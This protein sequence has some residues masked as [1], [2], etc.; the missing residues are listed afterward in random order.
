MNR[1]AAIAK[2]KKC[3]ALGRSAEAHE[4]AA[5]IRQAQKLMSMFGVRESDVSLSDVREV[6]VRASSTAAN[7]W[8]VMLSNVCADCF[9][10]ETYGRLTAAYNEAGNFIRTR[11]FVFVGLDSAADV[12]AYCYEVLLR[13]AARQRLDHIRKQPRNCKPITK[14]A[15]GDAFAR[16]WVSGVRGLVERFAQPARDRQ[17]LIDYMAATHPD[18]ES[19]SVRDSTRKR[20]PDGS[21]GRS[22]SR[23][24]W[25]GRPSIARGLI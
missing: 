5:A 8:D 21:A 17:L 9:C 24:R 7:A 3:L 16:G 6:K 14:T 20:K 22:V 19:E 2:I 1:D 18:M 15:R 25:G 23:R 10:C 13:Q 12:A 11:Y 4:A